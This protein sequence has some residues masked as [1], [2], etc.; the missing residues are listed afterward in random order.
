[1]ISKNQLI[2]ATM[3][4]TKE[5]R[6]LSWYYVLSTAILMGIAF[7]LTFRIPSIPLKIVSGI[8]AGLLTSRMFVIYHDYHH[9]A[10]LRKSF[11]AKVLMTIFGVL[12]LAPPSIWNESHQHH[13]T[14]NS[15][16]SRIVVGSFPTIT[17]STF[18][19][20]SPAQR[21]WYLLL[22]HPLMILFAYVP[23]FLVSFC[24]WP[25]VENPKKY[26][27]CGVAAILHFAI[28]MLLYF[29]GEWSMVVY[30]LFIPCVTMF[31]IGG[32]IFYA[33]HNFP[34]VILKESNQW[35]YMDAALN[36]SSYIRMNRVMRWFTANI[37]YHHIHHVNSRIPFYRLPEVM[38]ALVEFQQPR[39]TSLHPTEIWNCLQ[40]KLWDETQDRMITLGE[41]KRRANANSLTRR[42]SGSISERINK[43]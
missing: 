36:S 28:A 29:A 10:I 23:I 1:M 27:D 31:A 43:F 33:Q 16:F 26:W 12:T 37:G 25:F 21:S 22:R 7:F 42:M 8:L 19:R 41:F 20:S 6:F 13:H 3:R 39:T 4:F 32:Y 14:H 34:Q 18:H 17:V 5:N 11:V 24:L 35:D 30:S 9:E 38:K 15:K 40:L 2:S